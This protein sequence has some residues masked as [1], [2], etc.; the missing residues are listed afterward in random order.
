MGRTA[1]RLCAALWPCAV[2]EGG[3]PAPDKSE[4]ATQRADIRL[5]IAEAVWLNAPEGRPGSD[6]E[7]GPPAAWRHAGGPLVAS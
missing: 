3:R 1:R 6:I 7:E 5:E 2:L 4:C